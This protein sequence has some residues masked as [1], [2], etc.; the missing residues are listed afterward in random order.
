MREDATETLIF[1]I[2]VSLYTKDS[3]TIF[4]TLVSLTCLEFNCLLHTV[5][6]LLL[7]FRF[8]TDYITR[9]NYTREK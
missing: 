6:S 8:Y 9:V 4:S 5:E 7:L 2:R 1:F 3:H